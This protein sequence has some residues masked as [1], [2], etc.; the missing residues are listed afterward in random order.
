MAS[1][2]HLILWQVFWRFRWG[3]LSAATFLVIAIALSHLLPVKWTIQV[4]GGHVPAVGWLLGVSCLFVNVLLVS[5]FSMSGAGARSCT[6]A[7]DQFVLPVRTSALVAWPLISGGLICAGVWLI[8]ASLVFRPAG[9]A[10]PLW[11]PAAAAALFLATFQALAWTPFAQRWL[12]G[13][14]TVAVV[15]TPLLVL[16]LGIILDIRLSEFAA[17]M[18][19]VSLIPVA[20]LAARSGVTRARRGDLYDWRA[21]G[22]FRELLAR[23]WP[24][25]THPFRSMSRAQLWYEC[26]AHMIVPVFIACMLPCFLFVPA[27]E[28]RDVALGWRLLSMLLISP[29]LVA[30]L[31]GGTLGSLVDPLSK[32]ESSTFVLAR[33]ISSMAIVRDK[34]VMAAL[35]TAA[36]WILFLGYISLLLLRPGFIQSIERAASSVPAWKAVGYPMLVLS[37]LVVFTWKTMAGTLWVGLTGRRWVAT[38]VGLGF[39]GLIFVSIGIGLWIQFHPELQPAARAA[40]PWLLGLFLAIKLTAAA[41]VVYGLLHWRLTTAG[42]ATLMVAM[43]LGV[44]I[45]LCGLA[46]ALLPAEY[47]LATHVIPGIA[48]LIP[49]ARLVGAPLALVWHRHR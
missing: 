11:W 7:G 40:V 30:M 15:M 47:A 29:V 26:R 2:A 34:L 8:N 32:N 35:M 44:V 13:V 4:G 39:S 31:S 38:T 5:A 27:L 10:A 19:L 17:T 18:L 48:I 33:P 45:S 24:A 22:R 9:I 16:L 6:F 42:G 36:I 28:P 23:R 1:P 21:W 43:W 3:F 14:V 37:L 12:H 46:L 49:F 20:Y 25:A 41:F